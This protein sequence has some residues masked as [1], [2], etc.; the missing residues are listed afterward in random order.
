M[1]ARQALRPPN[2]KEFDSIEGVSAEELYTV[3]ENETPPVFDVRADGEFEAS[4]IENATH[5]CLKGLSNVIDDFPA[6]KNFY[7]YCAG[8]YRS[9]IAASILKNRGVHNFIDVQGGF[10]AIK[11]TKIKTTEFVCPSTL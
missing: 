2:A 4:H 11:K 1:T 5:T 7:V 9:V 10:G 8:G 6:D 3:L